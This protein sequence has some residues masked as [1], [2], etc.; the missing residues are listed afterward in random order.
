MKVLLTSCGL[1][2]I[3]IRTKYLEL[4]DRDMSIVKA[5]FIPTA[6]IDA[7]AISVLPMC[8]N[9]LLN[10]NILKEN[11]TVYDLHKPMS[12]SEI[13]QYDIVYICGGNTEYLLNR[14][15]EVKFQQSLLPYINN[16]GVVVGV[17]AGSV[18]FANNLKNNLGLVKQDLDVHCNEAECEKL[19]C[20]NSERNERIKL[21]NLQALVIESYNRYIIG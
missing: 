18:I 13:E 6:A 1:E 2:T 10:C 9:D 4:L 15:N 21:G 20:L 14:I 8:M 3:G 7:D 19:G 12:A 5:L 16:D 11:I 17:S